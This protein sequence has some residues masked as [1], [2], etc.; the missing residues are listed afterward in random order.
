[1][2]AVRFQLERGARD[3]GITLIE[4]LIYSFLA[5]VVL[6]LVGQFLINSLRVDTQVRN[7]AEAA[8]N[9]QVA[10]ASIGRG[11]RNASAVEVVEVEPGLQ[12]L[13]TRSIGGGDTPVWLCQAWAIQDGALRW[14]S[15][16]AAIPITAQAV[17]GWTLIVD[18]VRPAPGKPYFA[19]NAADRAVDFAFTIANGD[20]APILIDTT[21]I[22]RQPIPATGRV[23]LPCFGS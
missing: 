11:V 16:D 4:L 15:S 14:T 1:M 7:G 21:A 13:R 10:A 3:A 20:G 2:V 22:S 19:A 5:I 9:A 18:N 12:V 6:T 23:S 17:A 8:S